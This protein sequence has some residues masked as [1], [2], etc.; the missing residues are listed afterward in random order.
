[1]TSLGVEVRRD[2]PTATLRC[3]LSDL[4]DVEGY[5]RWR[6]FA[7]TFLTELC[8]AHTTSF[9]LRTLVKYDWYSEFCTS[10]QIPFVVQLLSRDVQITIQPKGDD[11]LSKV[12]NALVEDEV[13][14]RDGFLEIK[15]GNSV[16]RPHTDGKWF[17]WVGPSESI[18]TVVTALTLSAQQNMVRMALSDV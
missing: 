8:R 13:W 1:M 6:A 9:T 7:A 18:A 2:G 17:E 10:E 14:D 12:I 3:G 11:Q 4:R 15:V 16:L 5:Q